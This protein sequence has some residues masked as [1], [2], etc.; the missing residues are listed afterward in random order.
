MKLFGV[1]SEALPAESGYK[2]A[3]HVRDL[4]LVTILCKKGENPHAI[5]N[6]LKLFSPLA[7]H[8]PLVPL[9]IMPLRSLAPSVSCSLFR[10][11]SQFQF[12]FRFDRVRTY[13]SSVL[14]AER[15]F[16]VILHGE[17][18]KGKILKV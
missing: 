13:L 11:V 2:D 4:Q 10:F 7:F 1:A 18:E 6:F 17:K 3:L 12:K 8:F 9:S 14:V 5:R 15:V 16:L